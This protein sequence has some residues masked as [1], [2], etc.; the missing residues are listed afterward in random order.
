MTLRSLIAFVG[1]VGFTSFLINLLTQIDKPLSQRRV[2]NVMIDVLQNQRGLI[3]TYS[4]S[5]IQA[6]F[7]IKVYQK[8]CNFEG[9]GT[10]R[11]GIENY[12]IYKKN[13]NLLLRNIGLFR[14]NKFLIKQYRERASG[15]D[16]FAVEYHWGHQPYSKSCIFRSHRFI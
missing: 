6:H 16:K 13:R 8:K 9:M 7:R 14:Y 11:P 10:I 2:Q 1:S 3:R 4:A 5:L 15:I 12:K